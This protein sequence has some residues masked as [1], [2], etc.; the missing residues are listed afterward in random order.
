MLL[1]D[2][3]V[4][5]AANTTRL[6]VGVNLTKAFMPDSPDTCATLYETGGVFP[7]HYFSTST[8]TRGYEQPALQA[9]SRSTDYQTARN[10]A[11]DIFTLL[12]NVANTVLSTASGTT[13]VSISAV[14]SPFLIDR[15]DNDRFRV[16]VNFN[17]IKTTG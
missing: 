12:D 6:S 10:T 3:A 14:Q 8:G 7:L 9:I 2:T 13:Y 1:D 11:E 17:I 4:Y 15:D 16:G 5:L